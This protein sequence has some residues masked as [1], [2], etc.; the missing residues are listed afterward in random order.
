MKIHSVLTVQPKRSG[1]P[2][3]KKIEQMEE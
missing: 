1:L 3:N 2:P